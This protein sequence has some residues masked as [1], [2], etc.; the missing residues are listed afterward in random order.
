[1]SS[2]L[3]TTTPGVEVEAGIGPHVHAS[4]AGMVAAMA[5]PYP[6][7][8]DTKMV[9]LVPRLFHQHHYCSA[10]AGLSSTV[11]SEMVAADSNLQPGAN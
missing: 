1:M 4:S 2:R 10:V 6:G 8:R 7:C 9:E 3:E 11:V 5:G